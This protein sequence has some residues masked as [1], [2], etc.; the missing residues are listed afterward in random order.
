MSARKMPALSETNAVAPTRS[1]AD[2]ARSDANPGNHP[3]MPGSPKA[4]ARGSNP[5]GRA[6][7][8]HAVRTGPPPNWWTPVVGS[9]SQEVSDGRTSA[10]VVYGRLQA[11]GC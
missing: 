9:K 8:S 1:C 7:T 5:F 10:T 6:T 2:Q 4:E 3:D 11:A